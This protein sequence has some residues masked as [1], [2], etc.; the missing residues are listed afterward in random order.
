MSHDVSLTS[1]LPS[2]LPRGSDLVAE[3]RREAESLEIVRS[4]YASERGVTSERDYK[5]QCRERGEFTTYI[6]LGFKTWGETAAAINEINARGRELGFFLDHVTLI[7]DRRMGLPADMRDQALEETG[8][9]MSSPADWVGTGQDIASQCMWADHNL[10]SPAACENTEAAIRSG[11]CYIGNLAQNT[12]SYSLWP[13]DVSQFARTVK[14]LGMISA[15][16]GACVVE[17]YIDDGFCGGFHD[18]ATS[19]GWCL[20]NRYI[21]AEL[22]GVE[23][24]Q[25]YGS[26]F[27]S[28]ELKQAFGLALDEINTQRTPPAFVHGDTNSFDVDDDF[29]R[30]AAL[31]TVDAYFSAVR[32]LRHPSGAALH[33]T[34]VTEALRIPTIDDLVQ[35]LIILTE[36]CARARATE[37]L[38][39]WQDIYATRDRILGGG[40][41]VFARMMEGLKELGVD[42]TDPL[43]ILLATHRLG[44][45]KLEELF[46]VGD[47][48]PSYPRGFRPI[49][50]SD[51]LRRL[52]DRRDRI[53]E[54]LAMNGKLPEL[55]GARVVAASADIH[56]Y[57]LFLIVDVLQRCGA[58]VVD[59][60]TSVG[61]TEVAEVAHETNAN[62]VA[63]STYN[64]MAFR[65]GEQLKRELSQR[66]HPSPVFLGGRLIEDRDDGGAIDVR[67]D[68]ARAGLHPCDS[69]EQMIEALPK[70]LSEEAPST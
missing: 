39:A 18:L 41:K 38:I 4:R 65:L 10:S 57:G 25:S 69:I 44:G 48:D 61:A 11:I 22:V 9:M 53:T 24:S 63:V 15:K 28:P 36:A 14:A 20:M 21:T 1:L 47:P 50:M 29:D 40:R 56:E 7:P 12:Y 5:A 51:T 37:H 70:L 64:G 26:T 30:N 6:N 46:G 55:R 32:E 43:Q 16:P 68:L 19:L 3:G 35:S 23:E 54:A 33:V 58:E 45:A 2:D 67:G 42:I 49:V 59:L 27:T 62:A 34:P 60:G 52:L 31:L 66:E 17:N 8:L 13:D